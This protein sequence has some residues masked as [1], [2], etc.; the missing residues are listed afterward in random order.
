MLAG[1]S[2]TAS[3]AGALP[4]GLGGLRRRLA[5]CASAPRLEML[6]AARMLQAVGG[7]C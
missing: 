4:A 5:L 1:S 3:A 2:P 7:R 6:I